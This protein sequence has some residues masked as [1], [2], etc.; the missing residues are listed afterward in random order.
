MEKEKLDSRLEYVIPEKKL[1]IMAIVGITL[2][3]FYI[4]IAILSLFIDLDLN[5]LRYLVFPFM[6]LVL[7]IV[8][9]MSVK[10]INIGKKQ[11]ICYT[12]V[13]KKNKFVNEAILMASVLLLTMNYGDVFDVIISIGIVVLT[14]YLIGKIT[15][16]YHCD[17][18][19]D[20][21]TT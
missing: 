17:V 15:A 14:F 20:E 6:I 21:K 10:K 9:T 1:T 16:K 7:L 8:Y 5:L 18:Y 11:F 3:I 12:D 2:F 19:L 13:Y 4:V